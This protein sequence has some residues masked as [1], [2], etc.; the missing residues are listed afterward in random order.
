MIIQEKIGS[1]QHTATGNRRIERVNLE[2][3]ETAK[4]ILHKKTDTGRAV[5]MKFFTEGESLAQDDILYMDHELVICTNIL[6]T[7]AIVLLPASLKAMA[8]VC[9]EIG[10]K[11]LPLF[12]QDGEL[13]MPYDEPVFRMLVKAGYDPRKENRKLFAQM[14][15]SVAAH[16]HTG[17]TLFSKILQLTSPSDGS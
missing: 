4:K 7:E 3:H 11:H 1:L 10:N 15:T 9:Y 8:Y 14:K 16:R 12:Y 13:A 17:S 2:W 6:P 5:I